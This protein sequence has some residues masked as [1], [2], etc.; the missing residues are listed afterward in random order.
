MI[1]IKDRLTQD[2]LKAIL[3]KYILEKDVLKEI[4]NKDGI[5]HRIMEYV[6]DPIVEGKVNV[7]KESL[8]YLLEQKLLR[9]RCSKIYFKRGYVWNRYFGKYFE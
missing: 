7:F 3:K 2:Q 4:L 9:K 8:E 1:L 6:E 5:K